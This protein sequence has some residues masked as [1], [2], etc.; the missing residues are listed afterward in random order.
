MRMSPSSPRLQLLLRNVL[1][2]Q[3]AAI[4]TDMAAA[5]LVSQTACSHRSVG[6]SS[7]PLCTVHVR[8]VSVTSMTFR[9]AC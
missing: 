2:L 5:R 7:P 4:F 9:L 8:G 3:R 1:F 6:W